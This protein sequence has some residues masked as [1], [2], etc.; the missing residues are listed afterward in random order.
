MV[1]VSGGSV[2]DR[3]FDLFDDRIGMTVGE[4]DAGCSKPRRR[5][6]E[7][8]AGLGRGG[9]PVQIFPL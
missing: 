3:S 4:R 6:R 1:R 5:R 9:F 7:G 2:G 8:G